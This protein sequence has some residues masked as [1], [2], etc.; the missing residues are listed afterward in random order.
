MR[1]SRRGIV[2]V[3]PELPQL[4]FAF[5]ICLEKFN[6]LYSTEFD[7]CSEVLGEDTDMIAISRLYD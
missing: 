3:L 1:F 7:H 2:L 6:L 5:G 4:L